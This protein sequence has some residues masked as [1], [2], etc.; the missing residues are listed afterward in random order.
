M[1]HYNIHVHVNVE[2]DLISNIP[3]KTHTYID[4]TTHLLIFVPQTIQ[5]HFKMNYNYSL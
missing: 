1:Y 4:I 3:V 5:P 2:E